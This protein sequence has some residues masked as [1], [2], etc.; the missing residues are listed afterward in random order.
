MSGL[1]FAYVAVSAKHSAF[2]PPMFYTHTTV[3][4]L[5]SLLFHIAEFILR[6]EGKRVSSLRIS[7]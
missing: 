7:S 2:F 3:R 5:E 4:Q 6:I 1:C